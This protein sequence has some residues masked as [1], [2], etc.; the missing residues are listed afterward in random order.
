MSFADDIRRHTERVE[1]LS[2]DV[3]VDYTIALHG[4]IAD[5]SPITGAPGQEVD[6]SYLLNSWLIGFGQMPD[7]VLDGTGP[8]TDPAWTAGFQAP[9]ITLPSGDVVEAYIVTN[10][11]YAPFREDGLSNQLSPVGGPHSVK[12][13]L[14]GAQP[15]LDSVVRGLTE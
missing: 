13:T 4:S 1:G 12:L 7:F 9:P 11:Q 14:A 3:I 6:T 8:D 10:T 15:L 5:G 2:Q